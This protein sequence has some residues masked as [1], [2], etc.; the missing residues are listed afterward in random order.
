MSNARYGPALQDIRRFPS[1]T[2]VAM[3][4][5]LIVEDRPGVGQGL[6]MLLDAESDLSVVGEAAD[7]TAALALTAALGPDV[8][9]MDVDQRRMDGIATTTA[10]HQAFPRTPIIMLSI[11]DD[12]GARA[13][14]DGVGAA[15]LVSKLM[16]ADVLVAAI[17]QVA[18]GLEAASSAPVSQFQS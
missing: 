10:L 5:L 2:R 9:L 14:A 1:A 12:A 13:I 16:P 3:I 17:R 15:A 11:D 8:V 7:G 6:R 18:H 4:R